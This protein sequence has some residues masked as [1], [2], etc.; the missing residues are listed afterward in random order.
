MPT[1]PTLSTSGWASVGGS[2]AVPNA[3]KLASGFGLVEHMSGKLQNWLHGI[4]GD[5]LGWLDSI[6][7]SDSRLLHGTK[8]L[9]LGASDFAGT[10]ATPSYGTG[11]LIGPALNAFCSI[12]LPIGKRI[13]AVRV[14]IQDNTTGPTKQR[15]QFQQMQNGGIVGSPVTSSISAGS[16][17]NQTLTVSGLTATVTSTES[18]TIQVQ[19]TTGSANVI[20]YGAEVDYDELV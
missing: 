12:P 4:T 3:G 14:F 20:I 8:T 13:T 1:K 16:G 11:E 15:A 17:A 6:F 7:S 2:R 18:P 10:S 9:V 19:T 5:W